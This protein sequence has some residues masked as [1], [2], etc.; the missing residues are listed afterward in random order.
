MSRLKNLPTLRIDAGKSLA[1]TYRGKSCRGVAGDTVATAL[2]ANGVRVF[3]RSLKYHRPRGLYSLDGECSNAMVEVDGVP[4]VRAETTPLAAGMTVKPQNVKGSPELDLMGFMDSLSWAMPA[5]F[6]YRVFHKPA[7]LWP[8]AIKQIRQA[9]GLGTLSPDFRMK[10][11]FDEIYPAADLC[12]IG[13]GPAG[14]AAALARQ[15]ESAPNIRVFA[16]APA[17]GVYTDGQ[18]TAFQRGGRSRASTSAMS[19][20][21]PARSWRPPAA[22]SGRCSSRTTSGRASCR[23]SAHCGSPAPGASCRAGRRS[24][25]SA[26]TRGSRPQST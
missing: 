5:G 9:A 22:S 11:R 6:Y 10:G 3:G 18:V 21:A 1:F 7:R 23:P 17:I 12:V 15:V 4:N 20:S 13:G 16:H 19:R 8:T 14:M 24:S 25:A 26:T 2:F